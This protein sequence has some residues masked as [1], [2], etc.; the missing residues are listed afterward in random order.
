M[1]I[2]PVLQK[3]FAFQPQEKELTILWL[4]QNGFLLKSQSSVFLID[5]Y[6]SDFAEQWTYGWPNEHVRMAASPV[7]PRDL[8]GIDYVL[9]THDHVDHIDPFTIP[10]IALRNPH[11]Q[12]IAPQAA[13]IRMLGLFVKESKLLLMR[14]EDRLDLPALTIH[15]IPAAHST[16]AHDEENGYPFLSFVI[17]TGG[18]TLF[19]AGDTVWYESQID[20]LRR[21]SIDLAF[22]PINGR[23]PAELAFEPN[24]TVTEAIQLAREIN[25]GTVIPMHYDM[26]TLNTV[27]IAEF[28][29]AAQGVVHYRIAQIGI[30]FLFSP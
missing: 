14:G 27:N 12:F 23:Q 1:A 16:L 24:F 8:L 15:A 11:T 2:H 4:G 29:Q 7:Q 10:I 28:I 26:Y 20:Y 17:E 21:F 3:F 5:P 13:R 30:P 22:L 18:L 19:H 9:C 25:A 6:L